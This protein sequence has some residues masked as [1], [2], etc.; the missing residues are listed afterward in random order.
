MKLK[1]DIDLLTKELINIKMQKK[2]LEEER[3]KKFNQAEE[4]ENLKSETIPKLRESIRK[5]EEK[6]SVLLDENKE[7]T[8]R[9]DS[10]SAEFKKLRSSLKEFEISGQTPAEI[11]MRLRETEALTKELEK[12]LSQ[13]H[14]ECFEL[15]LNSQKVAENYFMIITEKERINKILEEQ[16]A[17]INNFQ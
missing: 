13:A 9:Y 10:L 15:K 12:E 7:I 14:S 4:L 1:E 6:E 8:K 5:L 2:N 11:L 17:E 3:E 16:E